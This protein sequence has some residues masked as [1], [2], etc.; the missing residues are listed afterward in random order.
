MKTFDW[1]EENETLRWESD[2]Y[3]FLKCTPLLRNT[4][5]A[6]HR[7]S[8]G[9]YV[10]S[11]AR[12]V[13]SLV[14]NSNIVFFVAHFLRQKNVSCFEFFR[15]SGR[16]CLFVL[17]SYEKTEFEIKWRV[18]PHTNFHQRKYIRWTL[19]SFSAAKHFLWIMQICLFEFWIILDL[20]RNRSWQH[21]SMV[22]RVI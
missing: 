12:C 4:P 10:C 20:I 21:V 7:K 14:S 1:K 18:E 11:L 19:H 22:E 5:I 2:N 6:F 9:R 17:S 15:F 3:F 8:P 13:D 16:R